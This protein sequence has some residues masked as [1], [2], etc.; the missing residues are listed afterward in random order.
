M[1]RVMVSRLEA[2]L[3]LITKRLSLLGYMINTFW[4]VQKFWKAEIFNGRKMPNVEGLTYILPI[5]ISVLGLWPQGCM[6]TWEVYLPYSHCVSSC[7]MGSDY[8]LKCSGSRKTVSTS[9]F[10]IR[11]FLLA[12]KSSGI[13]YVTSWSVFYIAPQVNVYIKIIFKKL[14]N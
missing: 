10:V 2:E 14:S 4:I 12:S 11:Y 1:V 5:S 9:L 6:H 8:S 3:Q 7:P 13:I